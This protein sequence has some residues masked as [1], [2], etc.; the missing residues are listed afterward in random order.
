MS[1]GTSGG[2]NFDTALGRA[3][4]ERGIVGQPAMDE[5]LRELRTRIEQSRPTTLRELLLERNL[6]SSDQLDQIRVEAESTK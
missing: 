5:C 2:T 6:T 1:A 4:V 3:L